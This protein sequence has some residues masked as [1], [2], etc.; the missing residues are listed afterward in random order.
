[1]AKHVKHWALR[2]L[3]A[4]LTEMMEPAENFMSCVIGPF[5][6]VVRRLEG[7]ST[8]EILEE[9]KTENAD[10]RRRLAALK[11]D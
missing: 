1:M 9:L 5:D 2:L 10:L 6:V 7:K 11:G 4:N 8:T 3:V